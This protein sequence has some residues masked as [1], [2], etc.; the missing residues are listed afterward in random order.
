MVNSHSEHEG[1]EGKGMP[2]PWPLHPSSREAGVHWMSK[3][4]GVAEGVILAPLP[5][6]ARTKTPT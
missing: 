2:T 1:E 6:V 4:G 3:W 5:P